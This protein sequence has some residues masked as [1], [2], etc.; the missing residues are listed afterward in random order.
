MT[1]TRDIASEFVAR[2][3]STL[4]VVTTAAASDIMTIIYEAREAGAMEALLDL[5]AAGHVPIRKGAK[6]S[7][8]HRL[9]LDRL[10]GGDGLD[11][12]PTTA[13]AAATRAAANALG[14]SLTG[15]P[16]TGRTRAI[17]RVRWAVWQALRDLGFS[18]PVISRIDIMGTVNHSTVLVALERVSE[19]STGTEEGRRMLAA[20]GAAR[21]ELKTGDND[22]S[23]PT[24]P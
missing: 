19:M 11:V 14:V 7:E 10:L 24:T 23:L 2:L 17:I 4:S 9:I 18:F 15:S 3:S 1:T 5:A 8:V 21:S 16:T 20:I 13:L 12:P 6:R 22:A